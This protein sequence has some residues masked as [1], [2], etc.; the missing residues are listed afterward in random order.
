MN[1]SKPRGLKDLFPLV[2]VLLTLAYPF[3]V[4]FHI[5]RVNP[6]WFGVVLLTVALIRLGVTWHERR[7]SDWV[8][9]TVIVLFCFGII[10]LESAILLRSYPVIMSVGMGVLFLSSLL[11]E[12]T[13]I[14]RFARAGGKTPPEQAK[15]YLRNL[16]LIWGVLLLS[17]GVVA[18]W[19]AWYGS[20]ATWTWYNGLLSYVI[21]GVFIALELVYRH[22]YKKKHNII[23]D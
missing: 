10:L 17:N 5:D 12:H 1:T 15:G 7:K 4:Y 11:D 13:L 23:D 6:R 18:A 3:V 19:T 16:T 14:E 21:F 8:M 9:T 2:L 22:F 20:L